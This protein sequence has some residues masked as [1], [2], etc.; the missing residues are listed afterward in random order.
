MVIELDSGSS[1]LGASPGQ[2]NCVAFLGKTLYF[3]S[4]SLH[5]G[6]Y[7]STG[8]FNAGDNP[9]MDWHP[10]QGG[11]KHSKLLHATKLQPDGTLGS[12]AGFF[13]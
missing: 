10:I 12:Y 9:V 13:L 11:V 8:K 2:R 7:K 3:H 4:A 5:P 1:G 6:V